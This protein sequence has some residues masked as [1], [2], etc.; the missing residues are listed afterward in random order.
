MRTATHIT[1][2]MC[3]RRVEAPAEPSLEALKLTD[4]WRVVRL[5]FLNAPDADEVSPVDACPVCAGQLREA[6]LTRLGVES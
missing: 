6:L 1:C 2:D 4:A 5:K 3:T